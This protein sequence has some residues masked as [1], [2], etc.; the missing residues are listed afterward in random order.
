MLFERVHRMGHSKK[1]QDGTIIPRPIIAKFSY[2]KQKEQVQKVGFN[3]KGSMFGV[4]EQFPQEIIEQRKRLMP[5]F[6]EAKQEDR[7]ARRI[8]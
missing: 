1:S 3:L 4:S 7:Y 6:K 5:K 2:F 8:F